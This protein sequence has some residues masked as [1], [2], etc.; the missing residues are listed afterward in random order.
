[1]FE[2]KRVRDFPFIDVRN[3][4]RELVRRRLMRLRTRIWDVEALSLH[5]CAFSEIRSNSA[6]RNGD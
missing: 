1:M 3:V 4:L 2:Y 6:W 5:Q